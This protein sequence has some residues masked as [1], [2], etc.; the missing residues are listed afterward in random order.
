MKH[1]NYSIPKIHVVA[2]YILTI[3]LKLTILGRFMISIRCRM[4]C[5][6]GIERAKGYQGI[7]RLI[8]FPDMELG[9]ASKVW[10]FHFCGYRHL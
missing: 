3:C 6:M 10:Q 7:V 8:P 2:L 9:K 4:L 1:S 5:E